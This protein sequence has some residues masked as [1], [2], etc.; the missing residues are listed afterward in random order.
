MGHTVEGKG[1]EGSPGGHYMEE[2]VG[3]SLGRAGVDLERKRDIL[4]SHT[5]VPTILGS[6]TK[7]ATT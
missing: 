5:L 1:L 3:A 7:Q 2:A 4:V 6:E